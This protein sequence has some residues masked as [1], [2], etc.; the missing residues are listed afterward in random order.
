MSIIIINNKEYNTNLYNDRKELGIEQEQLLHMYLKDNNLNYVYISD[1]LPFN[2][3]DFIKDENNEVK[4]IELKS[5]IGQI[6]THNI[7]YIDFAK[8]QQY[9]KLSNIHTN[10]KAY[11]IFNHIDVKDGS[12]EYYI[13]EVDFKTINDVCFLTTIKGKKTYELPIRHLRQ[14]KDNLEIIK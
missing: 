3:Y 1:E 6:E 2:A 14:L 4:I 8:I 9:K 10:L 13:Y 5:R 12:N 7:E 11:F